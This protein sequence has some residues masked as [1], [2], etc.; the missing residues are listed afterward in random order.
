MYLH[1]LKLL[2]VTSILLS[3]C[4]PATQGTTINQQPI[5]IAP[6]RA[7]PVNTRPVEFIVVTTDNRSKLDDQ[8][9]WYAITTSSYENL[10]YNM[11]ELIRYISQQQSEITYYRSITSN[12]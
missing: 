8:P 2:L 3:A 9:V 7:R 12:Q 6:E 4:T 11:Q 10:A 5:F 1:K